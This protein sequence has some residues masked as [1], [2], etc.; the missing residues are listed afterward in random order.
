MEVSKSPD[1]PGTS[2]KAI[3]VFSFLG[4]CGTRG[5]CMFFFVL[6]EMLQ[7]RFWCPRLLHSAL[8]TR[9]VLSLSS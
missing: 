5:H 9:K 2:L 1:P 6:L 8:K 7:G 3:L 4:T